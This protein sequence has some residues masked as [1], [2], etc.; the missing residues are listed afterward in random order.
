MI[1]PKSLWQ[2]QEVSP[3]PP[4]AE[5]LRAYGDRFAKQIRMRNRI[6]YAAAILVFAIFGLYIVIIPEPVIKIAS[7]MIIL[8]V[9]YAML[10]LHRRASALKPD[11]AAT[12]ET[13][14]SFHRAQLERQRKSSASVWFWYLGP[15]APGLALFILGPSLV[16]NDWNWGDLWRA[17]ICAAVFAGVWA[18]NWT[19]A[20]RLRREIEKL[21]ALLRE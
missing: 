20:R 2:R 19:T 4:T 21:D 14:V 3:T 11:A 15:M 16:H 10:Q 5:Q 9:A 12:A 7:A 13:A 6:E 8:G 1:D 18:L 17:L